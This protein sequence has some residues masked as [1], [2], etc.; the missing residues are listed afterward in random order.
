MFGSFNVK[1][2]NIF[3][4]YW[5]LLRLLRGIIGSS[6]IRINFEHVLAYTNELADWLLWKL[7]TLIIYV[8]SNRM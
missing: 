7:Y 4:D 3:V 2:A 6:W 1:L 8:C 5:V